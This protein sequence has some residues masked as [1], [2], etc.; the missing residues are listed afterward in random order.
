MNLVVLLLFLSSSNSEIFQALTEAEQSAADNPTQTLLL[1]Q[2]YR[3]HLE[4]MPVN[5]QLKWHKAAAR[6]ALRQVDLF[7]AE[8]IL[9]DMLPSYV[10]AGHNQ[11]DYFY[12]LVGIWFRKS[13][14]N[15]QALSAY[16]C[17]LNNQTND[18]EKLKYLNNAAIAAR[19][20]S[21]FDLS[22]R[23]TNQAFAILKTTPNKPF[24]AA[25]FNTVGITS[26][27][28]HQYIEAQNSFQRS[29]FL[30]AGLKRSSAQITTTLN[31]MT[32]YLLNHDLVAFKRLDKRRLLEDDISFDHQVYLSWLNFV[33]QQSESRTA[34]QPLNSHVQDYLLI[35]DESIINL[36]NLISRKLNFILPE[37]PVTKLSNPIYKGPLEHYLTGCFSAATEKKL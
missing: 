14:Y 30:R 25:V 20:L 22:M 10:Q 21:Q 11:K 3:P 17:A 27:L 24:E 1:Y 33:Y 4:A 8:T 37:H 28:N 18:S 16:Q 23:Y 13:A 26:L 29:L 7:G 6:A 5:V 2:Q 12:N 34:E 19:H 9:V 36:V 32:A 15:Q 35:K 31:L